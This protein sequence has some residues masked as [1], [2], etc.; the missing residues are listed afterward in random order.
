[1]LQIKRD[2]NL[3]LFFAG[4]F[5]CYGTIVT[6]G[7]NSN[8]IIKPYDY[9]DFQ[10]AINAIIPTIS[11]TIGSIVFSTYIKKTYNYKK[12]IATVTIGG[13]CMMTL[14]CIW[15]NTVNVKAITTIILLVTGFIFTPIVPLCYEL[16]CEL[17]FPMGEAQVIGFLNG[18]ALLWAFLSSAFVT[19]VFGFGS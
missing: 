8:F 18:G 16:G 14:L 5:L 10:I 19:S 1:M 12:A 13:T 3:W 15:L 17:T 7:A 2:R 4:Y 9:T 11:G 6:F